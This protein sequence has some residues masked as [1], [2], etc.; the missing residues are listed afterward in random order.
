MSSS[1]SGGVSPR[2]VV[3][4]ARQVIEK[5]RPGAAEGRRSLPVGGA[6]GELRALW[7]APGTRDTVLVGIQGVADAVLATGGDAG[8]WGTVVT[9]ELRLER[10]LPGMATQALAGKAVRRFK[11]LAE[12]GEAPTTAQNPSAREDAGKEPA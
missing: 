9:I 12:T 11:A 10:A 6:P 7:D 3:D 8:E 2:A 1:A 4:V 5:V